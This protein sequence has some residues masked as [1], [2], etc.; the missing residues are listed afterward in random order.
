MMVTVAEAVP[1]SVT[2]AV[3]APEERE[4]AEMVV[5]GA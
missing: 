1:E 4:V 3:N 2:T 5:V